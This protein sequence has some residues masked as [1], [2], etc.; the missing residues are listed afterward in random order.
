[1]EIQKIKQ[2]YLQ[3]IEEI[4]SAKKEQESQLQAQIANLKQQYEQLIQTSKN[5]IQTLQESHNLQ[6][7]ELNVEIERIRASTISKI[8]V[9]AKIAELSKS[10]SETLKAQENSYKLKIE[11]IQKT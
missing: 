5:E 8:E 1:M 11:D 7:S 10:Q 9:E 6:I 2:Q 4:Q 3:Q